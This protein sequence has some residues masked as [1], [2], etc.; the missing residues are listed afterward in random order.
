LTPGGGDCY[1]PARFAPHA[2]RVAGAANEELNRLESN[3]LRAERRPRGL[4][5]VLLLMLLLRWWLAT[6]P[7][8][9]PDLHAYK[10]WALTAGLVGIESVYDGRLYDYP[11]LYAYLLAPVGRL[12]GAIAP[13]ATERYET[14]RTFGDSRTFSLLVKLP[15]LAFDLLLALLLGLL[16]WRQ[17]MWTRLRSGGGWFPAWLYLLLPPALIC[18]GYWGQPDVIHTFWVFLGLALILRGRPE[19]GWGAAALGALMKPLAL[20]F[21][22]LLALATLV[23]CG[24]RRLFTAGVVAVATYVAGYLPFILTGRTTLVFERLFTDMGLMP[25]ASVNGHNLWW[26]L[27]PW[28]PAD[29]PHFGPITLTMIGQALFLAALALIFILLWRIE[30][31]RFA[32]SGRHL[33]SGR[34]RR[35]LAQEHHWFLAAAATA[36][37]FF[38]LSTHMHEN[39][40]FT[41][42]PFIVLLAGLGRRWLVYAV[43]FGFSIG[44]NMLLHDIY[45]AN[46]FFSQLGGVSSMYHPD[47]YRNLSWGE[48]IISYGNSL[49]TVTLFGLLLVW[50]L[51]FRRDRAVPPASA[52]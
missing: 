27:A 52:H 39:H 5:L 32:A 7:G 38:T 35:P 16:A 14:T 20:P 31:P 43:V 47:L 19:W 25:Y 6:T 51:R 44:I 30:R 3:D 45:L 13:E 4:L 8:Y 42:F 12:Y 36:L 10:R 46:E 2:A 40:S 50:F 33:W 48:V 37:A 24:W 11:P 17:R 22:P 29:V 49:L 26:L 28:K 15:P 23:V 21:F 34:R 18:A 41:A 1:D 9:P